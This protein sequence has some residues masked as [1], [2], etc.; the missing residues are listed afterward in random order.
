MGMDPD[1]RR[2][3]AAI[4]EAITAVEELLAKG[5]VPRSVTVGEV[6]IEVA[7]YSPTRTDDS[8]RPQPVRYR[9]IE[10][11]IADRMAARKTQA[12][13]GTDN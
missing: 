8:D 11:R 9:S 6:R 7:S 13:K 1:R 10:D 4:K 2:A 3:R 12:R 5:V